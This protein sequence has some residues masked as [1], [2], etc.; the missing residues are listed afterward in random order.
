MQARKKATIG[1]PKQVS[2][3]SS[4]NGTFA[5]YLANSELVLERQTDEHTTQPLERSEPIGIKSDLLRLFGCL[6][7]RWP[8]D[9]LG[10]EPTKWQANKSN[11]TTTDVPIGM[12]L[13]ECVCLCVRVCARASKRA[14]EKMKAA[15]AN[16]TTTVL[17]FAKVARRFCAHNW[18]SQC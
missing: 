4:A 16:E 5:T 10:P 2:A 17:A 14:S 15:R 18:N 12:A 6:L 9:C 3:R 7:V 8:A 11:A 1:V 13:C